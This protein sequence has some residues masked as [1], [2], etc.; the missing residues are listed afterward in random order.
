[1]TRFVAMQNR[2]GIGGAFWVWRQGCGS[3]ETGSDA[4]TSGNLIGVTCATGAPIA[5]PADFAQPLSA[6]YPRAFPGRIDSLKS[7]PGGRDLTFTATTDA[8]GTNCSLDI[9]IPG[10]AAPHLTT[11]GIDGLTPNKVPGGWQIGGCAHGTYTL[12]SEP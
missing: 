3:P 7:G 8:A 10:D 4:T 5:A 12:T 2:L 9:W 6:A 11:T 1:M